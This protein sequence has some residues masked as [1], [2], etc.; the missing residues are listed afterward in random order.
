M[1]IKKN[2][3]IAVALKLQE[4]EIENIKNVKY[5]T[6]DFKKNKEKKF[7]IIGVTGIYGQNGSGKTTIVDAMSILKDLLSGKRLEYIYN[8]INIEE[9]YCKIRFKFFIETNEKKYNL[10]FNIKLKKNNYKEENEDVEKIIVEE[11]EIKYSE[12]NNESNN[13]KTLIASS[14]NGLLKTKS[15]FEKINKKYE[16]DLKVAKKLAEKNSSSF[17]FSEEFMD[18]LIKEQNICSDIINIIEILKKYAL[19]DLIVITNENIGV[20]SLN[21]IFP[22]TVKTK[23]SFGSFVITDKNIV[24]DEKLYDE[25]E[26]VINQINIVLKSIIPDMKLKLFVKNKEYVNEDTINIVI[27]L[28]SIRNGK[29]ILFKNES[30]GIKRIVSI[31]SAVIAVYNDE[32]VCLV[33]DELDSGI[34]EYLLGELLVILADGIK[35]QFIFTSH[36]LR[37]LEK[38]DKDSIIFTT[39]N[40][41]NRYIKLKNIKPS[42]NLRDMYIREITMQE[43]K[44]KLY[45]E[46]NNGDIEFALYEA[47]VLSE[48]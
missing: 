4:I 9:K 22:L 36:N 18:I 6:I 35:G 28:V 20:I 39:T 27:Q 26:A 45:E 38:L 30:D 32:K 29:E 47:G 19:M 10:L 14:S 11:E 13:L 43:Q 15:F 44:E 12:I 1:E 24:I 41:K 2:E 31:L 33:V 16:V 7:K 23:K 3:N 34:F 21:T 37:V 48:R 5:G 17:I 25:I 40:E 8:L 46:T 42:N